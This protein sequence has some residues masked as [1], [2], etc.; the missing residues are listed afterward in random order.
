MASDAQR[1]RHGAPVGRGQTIWPDG[2][3]L[4]CS[5]ARFLG[6]RFPVHMDFMHACL[7][8]QLRQRQASA[9]AGRQSWLPQVEGKGKACLTSLMLPSPLNCRWIPCTA[10][11]PCDP[12]RCVGRA[13]QRGDAS[14]GSPPASHLQC[15]STGKVSSKET[16]A[17][18]GAA[19]AWGSGA[20][21]SKRA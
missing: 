10:H 21:A 13:M 17:R 11:A 12:C 1:P 19:L 20:E 18:R 2:R 15:R 5:Q 6:I 8:P 16:T 9:G 4:I 14:F 3:S 7:D